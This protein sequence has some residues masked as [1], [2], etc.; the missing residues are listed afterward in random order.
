VASRRRATRRSL[1]GTISDI[2]RRLKYLSSQPAPARLANQVVQRAAIR[3]RAVGNDQIALD[4]IA[5]DQIKADAIRE[6]QILDGEITTD[7]I[8]DLQITT[9]K[10]ADSQ[11]TTDKINNLDVT[12]AKLASN[13]VVT[14]KIR[15]DAVT[16]D[17]IDGGAVGSNELDNGS[18]SSGKIQNRAV[19]SS[20]IA[21]GAVGT[22]QLANGAVTNS[23]IS[24]SISGSKI[25]SGI[26][27]GNLN[28]GSVSNS[29]LSSG[30]RASAGSGL[31]KSGNTISV[32]YDQI[33]SRG[34]RHNYA[35]GYYRRDSFNNR[36][37]DFNFVTSRTGTASSQ[38]FKKSISIHKINN[39]KKLLELNFKK[40]KY[41]R[42][43]SH[44]SWINN[45]EWQ[46]GYL[47]EDLLDLGFEE[48]IYYSP[49]GSPERLDY[50][51]MSAL[52]LELVKIQQIEIESLQQKIAEMEEK[53]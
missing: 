4:A 26:S 19:G 21:D 28:N 9:A 22:S 49:E 17:K 39:P 25:G 7:K 27:G 15:N 24:G 14:S 50:S 33:P 11:I 43:M 48:V 41:K 46:Y 6:A 44:E 16:R 34:H 35:D 29:K 5:N 47:I 18:V 12:D 38:K 51:M 42:S 1:T 20:K 3:S 2:Q 31:R 10:I 37:R 40:F 53:R 36:L 45:K 8:R 30:T 23:K 52:V 13:A 32:N